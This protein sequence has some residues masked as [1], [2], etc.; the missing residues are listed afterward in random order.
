MSCICKA[1]P[2]P[3]PR[4]KGV[5]AR[6]RAETGPG[7]KGEVAVQQAE[8]GQV[9]QARSELLHMTPLQQMPDWQACYFKIGERGSPQSDHVRQQAR[10][11]RAAVHVKPPAIQSEP[12]KAPQFR[13]QKRDVPLQSADVRLHTTIIIGG[14]LK[15]GEAQVVQARQRQLD[16][17]VEALRVTKQSQLPPAAGSHRGQGLHL[18]HCQLRQVRQLSSREL[19][20]PHR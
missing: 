14:E 8:L 6:L 18:A 11:L 19:C 3:P 1:I 17:V 13:C 15:V 5:E 20:R 4:N 12:R 7:P 9:G 2:L 16:E 10:E